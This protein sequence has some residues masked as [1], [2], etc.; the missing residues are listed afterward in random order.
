MTFKDC[1]N[2]YLNA[3]NI[4]PQSLADKTGISPS[5]ISRYKSGERVPAP[6][7]DHIDALTDG[8][9]A[10][11]DT[12]KCDE[13][14][15]EDTIRQAFVTSITG[16]VI[17]YDAFVKN[18]RVLLTTFHISN[19]DF[20]RGISFDP[21]YVSRILDGKRRPANLYPFILNTS[22]FIAECI[23]TDADIDS[24]SGILELP[25]DHLT[26]A[27][28]RSKMIAAWLGSV[29]VAKEDPIASFLS[30]ASNFDL[31]DF[32]A[33]IHFDKIKTP[34]VPFHL[35]YTRIYTGLAEMMESELDFMKATVLSKSTDPVIMYSDMPM[36][37]MSKDPDFPKKW[38]FGMA[39]L[40][41]KG[42]TLHIIHNIDRPFE[43]M[44]LGLISY[45]PMYMTGQ[46]VPHY[47][48]NNQS[49]VF[50]HFVRYSGSVALMGE[51][52]RGHHAAGRYTLMRKKEDL[53]YCKKRAYSLLKQSKPLMQIFTRDQEKE[54]ITFRESQLWDENDR[55]IITYAP[56]IFTIPD[57]VLE[58]LLSIN[59]VNDAD[60]ER[61]V[62]Y[63]NNL[64]EVMHKMTQKTKCHLSYPILSKRD[65]DSH[66]LTLE[67]SDLFLEHPIVYSYE[68]YLAHTTATENYDTAGNHMTFMTDH[69][70]SFRN[71]RIIVY[72]G[73]F[74]LVSKAKAP[75]IHFAIHHPNMVSA[76]ENYVSSVT[77]ERLLA[78]S[79][80]SSMGAKADGTA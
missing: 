28:G 61:I 17:P 24:L 64:K 21:S 1:F 20:A 60:A 45:I 52:I 63:V 74:V 72:A 56:P 4:R 38:L 11:A 3:Y 16:I 8:I 9:M 51:A 59:K 26:T 68:D 37:E 15:D 18:L 73:H 2:H 54:F 44:M 53:L 7:S 12:T 47:L 67:L 57:T 23:A 6:D 79:S 41:K 58:H 49:D 13:P 34:T 25:K 40:L 42:L 27:R 46:I 71:I 22:D 14:L 33:S 36:D 77:D 66:P 69:F 29:S 5:V 70:L 30:T 31:N 10:L 39:C 80:S 35:P 43:E 55:T 19:Q 62:K 50:L 65:F 75:A 48:E 32:T 76:F 78:V